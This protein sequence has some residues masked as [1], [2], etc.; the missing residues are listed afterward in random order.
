MTSLQKNFQVWTLRGGWLLMTLMAGLLFYTTTFYLSLKTD[1]G[2]LLAK[3]DFVADVLWMSAFYMHITGSMLCL[4]IGPF[5]FIPSLR[6]QTLSWHRNL[7]KIYVGAILLVAGPSGLYMSFFA[8]GGIGA[9][10]GFL[11]L[12]ILWWGTTYLAYRA[13]RLRDLKAHRRWMLRS[14]ALTFSAVTLRTWVPILSL[15][16]LMDHPTIII[17]TSWLNW[18][19]NLLIA[20]LILIFCSKNL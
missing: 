10:I 7:G 8:N 2:F 5:Q 16:F 14:Y 18:I 13:I 17:V 3:Q 19:P 11:I 4:I 9:V 1:I 6:Q 12:S 20:E 15:W